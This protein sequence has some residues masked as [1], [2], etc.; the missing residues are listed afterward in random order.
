MNVPYKAEYF[1]TGSANINFPRRAVLWRKF[2][3]LF[4]G[5]FVDSHPRVAH[6]TPQQ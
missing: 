1:F 5:L 3:F 2:L 4:V 6:E